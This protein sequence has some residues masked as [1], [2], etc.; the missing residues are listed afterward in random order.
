MKKLIVSSLATAVVSLAAYGQGT[1]SM[2]NINTAAGV[3]APVYDGLTTTIKLAGA[4]YQAGLF[5]GTTS[6]SLTYIGNA[7]PFLT[8][9]GAG[10][11][12]GGT[13][14]LTGHAPGSTVWLQVVAWDATLKGTTTGATWANALADDPAGSKDVWGMSKPFSVVPA[15]PNS[16]PPGTPTPLVGLTS[17]TLS[18][19]EPSTFALAGLGMAAM[20]VLRRRK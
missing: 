20:L 11:F 3:N 6:T 14:V 12:N 7:T 19:P 13:T 8:A 17:F 15:D 1:V 2:L 9:G 18:V 16:S 4:N 10:Y 5:A